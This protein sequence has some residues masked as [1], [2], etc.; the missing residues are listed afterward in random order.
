MDYW[1]KEFSTRPDG[2]LSSSE[3]SLI[4]S[5]LSAGTFFG[6]LAAA[7]FGDLMGRRLGLIVAAGLVFNFGVILQTAST[8]QDL[9]IAGRFF[10]GF[11]VGLVSALSKSLL[12]ALGCPW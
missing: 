12:S 5:I 7:P 1:L 2:K 8:E 11:G 9:F 10:A 6:A 3:D 4:V